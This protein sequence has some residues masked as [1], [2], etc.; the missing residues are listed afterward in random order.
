[1]AL[2]DSLTLINFK[3]MI[4]SELTVLTMKI[5]TS[6]VAVIGIV[7]AFL[8]PIIPLLLIVGGA[9]LLDTIFGIIKAKKLGDPVTSRKMSKIVSK[10]VLYESAVVL[11]FC[12]EKFVLGDII[13]LFTSI[14]LILTK[15]VVTTL[16]FIEGTSINEN[17]QAISGVSIWGKF[18][19]LLSRGKELK[20]DFKELT[21]D[22]KDEKDT[23]GN[24]NESN[25]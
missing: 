25:I 11:F 5:K 4:L 6:L 7:M 19:S 13:G 24:G 20:K 14:P 17:Y 12:I 8:V 15:L 16:L 23:I 10:M 21:G 18:K 1:M 9:I 3:A 22:T 2:T